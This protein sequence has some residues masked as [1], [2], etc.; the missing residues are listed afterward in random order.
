MIAN[1]ALLGGHVVSGC[2]DS[3]GQLGFH[4]LYHE[5]HMLDTFLEI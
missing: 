4:Y 1:S 5:R 3:F 2:G